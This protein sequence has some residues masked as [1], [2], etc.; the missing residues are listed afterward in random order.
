MMMINTNTNNE[1]HTGNFNSDAKEFTRIYL[2]FIKKKTVTNE[3]K[4]RYY[5][6]R[7]C[8]LSKLNVFHVL[9]YEVTN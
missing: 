8:Y 4:L 5:F 1:I 6:Q 2:L 3:L 9:C 7:L